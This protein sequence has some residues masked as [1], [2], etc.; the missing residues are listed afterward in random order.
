M[1]RYPGA[2][3]RPLA[4]NWANQERIRP[5]DIVCLHTMV[6]TLAGTDAMFQ[7][8]GYRGTESHFGIGADGT[9]YQWQDTD[10]RA[11]ANLDGNYR[12]ISIET[13]DMG[14]EFPEWNTE[15][16]NAVPPWT[17]AQ[18]DEIAGTVAWCC[19][20]H[21]I[22]CALVTDSRPGRRGIAYHRQGCDGDFPDGRVPGGE[23]WSAAVGKV[24]PGDNRIAQIP[25]IIEKARRMVGRVGSDSPA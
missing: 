1:P 9:N 4:P 14:P 16:G 18:I 12:I 21:D 20:V 2:H 8:N 11:D 15:D 5:H 23:R 19:T 13:A 25:E 24:C 6:G 3:W 7:K 10:Y 22:P 17:D